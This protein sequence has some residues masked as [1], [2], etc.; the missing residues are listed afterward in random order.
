MAVSKGMSATAKAVA[1][2]PGYCTG[3]RVVILTFSAGGFEVTY[4]PEEPMTPQAALRAMIRTI[5]ALP[6]RVTSVELADAL[7]WI[8]A[9]PGVT[10]WE[11][12]DGVLTLTT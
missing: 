9:T 4:A 10:Y 12:G 11:A 2:R 8:T 7:G 5:S 6:C 1:D 3:R